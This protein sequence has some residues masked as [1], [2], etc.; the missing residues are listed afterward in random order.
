ML[1]VSAGFLVNQLEKTRM[2]NEEYFCHRWSLYESGDLCKH[3]V[4]DPF[5]DAVQQGRRMAG[6]ALIW[7][8]H[9]QTLEDWV[10]NPG[11]GC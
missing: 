1:K 5:P 9:G 2:G 7:E 4:S 8:E 10:T 3:W 6:G 11:P